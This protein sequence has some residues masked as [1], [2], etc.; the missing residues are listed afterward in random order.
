VICFAVLG[1]VA[2]ADVVDDN[3]AVAAFGPGNVYVFARAADGTIAYR[4]LAD[5]AWSGWATIPGFVGSSG[6]A[7]A[8]LQGTIQVF[9]RGN[10]NTIYQASLQDGNWSSWMQVTANA[11]SAPAVVRRRNRDVLDLVARGL[12]NTIWRGTMNPALASPWG[13]WESLGGNASAAPSITSRDTDTI[14]VYENAAGPVQGRFWYSGGWA[15]DWFQIDPT[16]IQGAPAAVSRN[17]ETLDV[18]GRG[19]DHTLWRLPYDTTN[20]WRGWQQVDGRVLESSPAVVSDVASRIMVFARVGGELWT[21]TWTALPSGA[22]SAWSSLGAVPSLPVAAPVPIPA[23]DGD[24][25]GVADAS[26]R[27][28]TLA[29]SAARAGCPPGVLADPSIAYRRVHGG[30]RVVAY[31]VKATAGARVVVSCSRGCRRTVVRKAGPRTV[32][33]KALSGK[34][35][36]NGTKITVSASLAGRLTTTVLD[37]VTRGRRVEGRPACSFSGRPASC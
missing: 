24:R 37:R 21:K 7:A 11:T 19:A 15:M 4:H 30:I 10:D 23:P 33:I 9:A 36:K 25:D 2:R 14:N 8:D 26:D 17:V 27:C 5:G 22:W 16:A 34:R 29:G 20:G 12:D 1:G 3:P 32:R 28:A 31:Y 13:G 18:F 6:P 35:L